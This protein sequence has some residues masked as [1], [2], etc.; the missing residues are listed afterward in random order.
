MIKA[1]CTAALLASV[2]TGAVGAVL[3]ATSQAGAFSDFSIGFNDDGDGLLEFSEVTSFSGFTFLGSLVYGTLDTI[4]EISGISSFGAS[5]FSTYLITAHD[6]DAWVFQN[7]SG[8]Y[9]WVDS[10]VFTYEITLDQNGGETET[11]A[12]VPLPATLPLLAGALGFFGIAARR[13][14]SRT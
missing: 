14:K 3:N 4:P 11:P 5:F 1:I 6:S 10:E 7:G 2:A 12:V 8:G 13:R 9:V